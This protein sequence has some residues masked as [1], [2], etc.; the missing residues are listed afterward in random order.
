MFTWLSQSVY[1]FNTDT[2]CS[3]DQGFNDATASRCP[4]YL[5]G[6]AMSVL[7]SLTSESLWSVKLTLKS[8][9]ML[10]GY[11]SFPDGV[12]SF[13]R[14]E[15]KSD[16]DFPVSLFDSSH[17]WQDKTAPEDTTP[18]VVMVMAFGARNIAGCKSL[19]GPS[20]WISVAWCSPL[21]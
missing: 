3:T 2:K 18:A 7:M 10:R 5:P 9:W 1:L 14:S 19:K 12:S 20:R 8:C 4:F 11:N 17:R 16:H 15:E 6:F 21:F 13:E